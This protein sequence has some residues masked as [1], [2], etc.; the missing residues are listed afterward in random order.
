[1]LD[2]AHAEAPALLTALRE[3]RI[4]GQTYTGECACLVGT[5]AKARGCDV[6]D[7]AGLKMDAKRPAERWFL[8]IRPEMPLSHPIV[9]ITEKWIADWLGARTEKVG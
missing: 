2:A 3:G 5:I 8:A 4:D 9:A 1:M 7:I 6:H